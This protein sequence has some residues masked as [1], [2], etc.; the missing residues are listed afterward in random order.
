MSDIRIAAVD[1]DWLVARI[2]GRGA[3]DV[4]DG[5]AQLIDSGELSV[6]SQLP[7]IRELARVAGVSVGTIADAWVGL[8]ELGLIETR[9]R[10]GTLVAARAASVDE[11]PRSDA[12]FPGWSRIDLVQTNA[13]VT[14]QPEL[15]AAL[16]SSLD[17]RDLNASGRDYMTDRLRAVVE[18]GWPFEA[19]AWTTAGGGT[20]ALLLATAA[21][22]PPGSIVAI[23]EPV[24]PGYLET[25]K[26]LGVTPIGLSSDES[27]PTVESLRDALARGAVAFVFQPGGPFAL[28]RSVSEERVRELAAAIRE[29]P[30]P[31]WVIEDDSIGPLA[32][33]TPPSM[34]A[35]IPEQVLRVRSFCKAYGIDIR[36]S[37]LGGSRELVN[38]SIA[39]RS[40]GVGSNS[41]ILQNALAH[42]IDSPAA[43]VNVDNARMRYATRRSILLEELDRVGLSAQSGPE[44]LVVWIEVE[45]ET[46][47]LVALASRGISVG[48]GRK[49][50]VSRP[51][52]GLLRISVTQ[53]P[54]DRALIAELARIVAGAVQG[55][56]REY[57]D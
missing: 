8:R 15:G 3:T 26:D 2:S 54:D 25:L 12:A 31:V 6:G 34:G 37:V 32:V 57:F 48:S 19:E 53:L 36:T 18:P 47:V 30:T 21:A 16:L 33:Q 46:D 14:L 17:A 55:S 45:N 22:A 29:H 20:E 43:K 44:S 49:T 51:E 27:G 11:R 10:G 7:T 13:D 39:E 23:D 1:A 41:R 40:H 9:R 42:L 50:F 56:L 24:V 5:V 28:D 52:R 35:V 38:R 4:R